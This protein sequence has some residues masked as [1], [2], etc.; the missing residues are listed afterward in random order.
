M[1]VLEEDG[2]KKA[3]DAPHALARSTPIL[4]SETFMRQES[5]ECVV[6]KSKQ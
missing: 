3:C 5:L 1:E 2:R 6:G 4:Y